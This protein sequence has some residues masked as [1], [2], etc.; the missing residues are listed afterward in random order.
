MRNVV[1]A[2]DAEDLVKVILEAANGM[3]LEVDINMAAAQP[4]SPWHIV[5]TRGSAV[6]DQEGGA[7]RVRHGAAEDFKDLN[8]QVGL[9][10]ANRAYGNGEHIQWRDVEFPLSD[11]ETVDFYQKCYEFYALDATPFVPFKE[12][13]ELMRVIDLCRQAD[14]GRAEELAARQA[15]RG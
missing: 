8:A 11:V 2:G 12:T 1:S 10:A 5:G 3:I 15:G 14:C 6:L 7:W 13:L 4:A 9:A